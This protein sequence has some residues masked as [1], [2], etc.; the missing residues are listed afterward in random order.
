MF[1][2]NLSSKNNYNSIYHTFSD[3]LSIASSKY[4]LVLHVL[5]YSTVLIVSNYVHGTYFNRTYE[6]NKAHEIFI[7]SPGLRQYNTHAISTLVV[8]KRN[9]IQ[10]RQFLHIIFTIERCRNPKAVLVIVVGKLG[11]MQQN[12]TWHKTAVSDRHVFTWHIHQ[13]MYKNSDIVVSQSNLK[14]FCS[15]LIKLDL[16]WWY[17]WFAYV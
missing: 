17:A 16:R 6:G 4:L 7:A 3:F 1:A 14:R 9:F 8:D 11:C 10:I 13:H 15:K 2:L 12:Y 5:S